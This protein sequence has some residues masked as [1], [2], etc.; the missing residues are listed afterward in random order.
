MWAPAK[1]WWAAMAIATSTPQLRA[2]ST[3]VRMTVEGAD[4]VSLPDPSDEQRVVWRWQ[5]D[6]QGAFEAAKRAVLVEADKLHAA[7]AIEALGK[8]TPLQL[9]ARLDDRPLLI[10]LWPKRPLPA[11][12]QKRIASVATAA[13]TNARRKQEALVENARFASASETSGPMT[14]E[15]TKALAAGE[16]AAEWSVAQ[17]GAV[18]ALHA[19]MRPALEAL[20]KERRWKLRPDDVRG[21]D[22]TNDAAAPAGQPGRLGVALPSV[23]APDRASLFVR[24]S[25]AALPPLAE[26]E[27]L[28]RRLA[29][30]ASTVYGGY[31]SEAEDRDVAWTANEDNYLGEYVRTRF[32]SGPNERVTLTLRLARKGDAVVGVLSAQGFSGPPERTTLAYASISG[33][34]FYGE[35]GAPLTVPMPALRGR[36]VQRFPPGN[37]KGAV[38]SGLALGREL[39]TRVAR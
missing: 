33:A 15:L 22:A 30:A 8:G 9:E 6:H 37:A 3:F 26:R 14:S 23:I 34:L 18:K 10:E 5:D 7:G 20:A 2:Q 1:V 11:A 39:F 32:L 16:M 12:D 25:F 19:R 27:E 35:A 36:F 28:A 31:D 24:V 29:L 17:Q 13:A 21:A 38:V 4:A